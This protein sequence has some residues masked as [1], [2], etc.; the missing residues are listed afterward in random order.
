MAFLKNFR[1]TQQNSERVFKLRHLLQRSQIVGAGATVLSSNW[2]TPWPFSFAGVRLV[3]TSPAY[4]GLEEFF[5]K[6]DV[7]EEGEETGQKVYTSLYTLRTACSLHMYGV[8][9]VGS[10]RLEN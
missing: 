6:G 3:H 1:L 8:M 10:G 5:P 9:Q 2:R 4:R 7:I